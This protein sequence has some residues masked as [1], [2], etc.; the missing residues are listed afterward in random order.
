MAINDLNSSGAQVDP[1]FNFDIEQA[2]IARQ[3]A[4]AQKQLETQMPQG[5]MVSGWYVAPKGVNYLAA[6]LEK[7][8]GGLAANQADQAEKDNIAAGNAQ[9][10]ALAKK[11]A[12]VK[13]KQIVDL[14]DPT[15]I[16]YEPAT[17]ND[18][19]P[20]IQQLAQSGAW[21]Q[22]IAKMTI[23]KDLA[24]PSFQKVADGE[25]LYQFDKN[26]NRIGQFGGGQKKTELDH[27]IA[28]IQAAHPELSYATVVDIA[29][30]NIKMDPQSG[31]YSNAATGQAPVYGQTT[32][33]STAPQ[34]GS[35]ANT[36]SSTGSVQVP[37]KRGVQWTGPNA[38]NTGTGVLKLS[39]PK[40]PAEYR[41][42]KEEQE[43]ADKEKQNQF[44]NADDVAKAQ[45]SLSSLK[46]LRQQYSDLRDLIDDSNG[47][48]PKVK[49]GPL[50]GAYARAHGGLLDDENQQRFDQLGTSLQL[51]TIQSMPG[52]SQVFNSNEEGKRL[53][54]ALPARNIHNTV[55]RQNID[56]ALKLV[57]EKIKIL[58]GQ[59][60]QM[61]T[62]VNTSNGSASGD[63]TGSAPPKF[64]W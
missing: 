29:T 41:K 5:Q 27:K 11:L 24:G 54:K 33:Q 2:R 25:T 20:I 60:G 28:A 32:G 15:K 9:T 62:P 61:G 36:S 1:A 40:T 10:F 34:N 59:L 45:T 23:D 18:K 49:T 12:D 13:G 46:A 3:R 8:M 63:S 57:D 31:L 52:M 37:T 19:L 17:F 39:N 16:S 30:G 42:N 44:K 6:G 51:A 56:D 4:L 48:A 14:N 55:N 53:T 38:E 7:M 22:Q 47:K 58:S 26:G 50:S 43:R 35:T 21:G 64:K